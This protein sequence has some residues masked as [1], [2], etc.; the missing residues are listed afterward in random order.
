[1]SESKAFAAGGPSGVTPWGTAWRSEGSGEP[2]VLI[3]GVGM[4]QSVWAPQVADLRKDFRLIVYDMIGHGASRYDP[5]TR[6]IGD[7]GNQLVELLN[8]LGLSKAHI[9]GHSMGALVAIE[10]AVAHGSRCKS[11]MALNGVYCRTA[12]QRRSVQDRAKDLAQN[13]KPDS[14]KET[15]SRWFGEPVPSRDVQAAQ[16]CTRLLT[17]VPLEGYARAYEIFS[18]SDERH[19]GKLGD[20][21]VPTMLVTGELDP[22]SSPAMSAAMHAE[23]AGSKILILPDQRHMMSLVAVDTVNDLIRKFAKSHH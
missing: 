19:L 7:Y 14:V 13:G 3:H 17:N 12:E 9:V 22:N 10:M 1:M 4:N 15:I 8:T 2:I 11:V 6:D 20:I 16:L 23:I 5:S 18:N 21:K